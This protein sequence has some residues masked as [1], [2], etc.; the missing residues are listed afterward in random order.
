MLFASLMEHMCVIWSYS[1]SCS[2]VSV[3]LMLL[4]S[5]PNRLVSLSLFHA[6]A[7]STAAP[8]SRSPLFSLALFHRGSL[9]SSS[10]SSPLPCRKKY[11]MPHPHAV[12]NFVVVS[13][14]ISVSP[15]V[16]FFRLCICFFAFSPSLL[17]DGD[18]VKPELQEEKMLL[19]PL[20]AHL[21]NFQ[22]KERSCCPS[23][24]CRHPL[25]SYSNAAVR[26][27]FHMVMKKNTQ[28][29]KNIHTHT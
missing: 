8:Y 5:S 27:V 17:D 28:S 4:C 26:S 20:M 29:N 16:S 11:A 18:V 13:F 24:L 1:L 12:T 22:E 25:H 15:S 21:T 9:L 7:S 3:I 23:S 14:L 19:F 6:S 10:S 2:F